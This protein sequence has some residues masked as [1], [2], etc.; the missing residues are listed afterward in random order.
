MLQTYIFSIVIFNWVITPWGT[1][2]DIYKH[3]LFMTLVQSTDIWY[4]M[5]GG[6]AKRPAVEEWPLEQRIL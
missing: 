1:F 2:V 4:T 3:G 5:A 6:A